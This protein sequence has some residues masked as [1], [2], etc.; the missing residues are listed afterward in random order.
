MTGVLVWTYKDRHT[1]GEHYMLMEADIRVVMLQAKEQLG[2]PE[3]GTGKKDS[4]LEASKRA[5]TCKQLDFR[6]LASRNVRQ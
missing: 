1:G 2:L 3:P 4:P 6:I 5:W